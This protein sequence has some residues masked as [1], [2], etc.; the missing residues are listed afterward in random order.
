VTIE[1]LAADYASKE[2][3]CIIPLT[4]HDAEERSAA[5]DLLVS[6]IEQMQADLKALQQDLS[7]K[8]E[9]HITD[10][11]GIRAHKV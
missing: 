6:Q 11:P 2:I 3:P 4:Q 10:L 1:A 5:E 8:L 7:T 9:G